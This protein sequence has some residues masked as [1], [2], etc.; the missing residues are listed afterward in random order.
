MRVR[1][2][3]VALIPLSRAESGC[4]KYELFQNTAEP[5]DFTFMETFASEAALTSHAAAPY[6]A[7]LPSQLSALIAKPSD[8]RIYR[9][10]AIETSDGRTTDPRWSRVD[11]YLEDLFTPPDAALQATLD[12][13]DEAGLPSIQVSAT[14]GK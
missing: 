11:A 4:L 3:L 10:V 14:Q 12:S 1:D 8:V 5:T 7:N 13:T 6:V 2:I 9:P